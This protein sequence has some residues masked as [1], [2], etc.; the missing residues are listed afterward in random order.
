MERRDYLL[1]MLEDMGRIIAR[2]REK[3]LGGDTAGAAQ[4]L[5]AA[6]QFA[7]LDLATI[8]SLTADSLL[9]IL[10][11]TGDGDPTRVRL[12]AEL[13]RADAEIARSCGDAAAAE[14]YD[15]KA[16]RLQESTG[17]TAR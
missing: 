7:G 16:A 1:R 12:A 15:A 9:L 8:R 17:A 4:E 3:L 10:R 14:L 2:L 5:Q 11:P 6:A 13:L